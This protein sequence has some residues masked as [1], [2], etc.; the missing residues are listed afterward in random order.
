LMMQDKHIWKIVLVVCLF[1]ALCIGGAQYTYVQKAK[2]DAQREVQVNKIVQA[3]K[4]ERTE[5]RSQFWQKLVPW[6]KDE[7]DEGK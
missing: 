7:V 4:T 3:E 6:G 2:I 5:E 1:L